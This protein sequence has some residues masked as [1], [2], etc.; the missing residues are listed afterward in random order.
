MSQSV[1][2]MFATLPLL[3]Q[4]AV[5]AILIT[6]L[7][8]TLGFIVGVPITFLRIYG[9]KLGRGFAYAYEWVLKGLPVLVTLFIL[10][11]GFPKLGIQIG[12]FAAIVIGLGLR[13]S[14]YQAQ[15]YRGAVLSISTE[16]TEAGLSLGLS[17]FCTFFTIIL[18][19]AF[20]LSLPG[21]TNEFTIV[22]KD[23]PLAY[24]VG[25][26]EILKQGRDITTTRGHT[27]A[28][29]LACSILYFALFQLFY[30]LFQQLN[31]K[32]AIPGFI[33]SKQ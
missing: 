9:N 2:F 15:I 26:V 23:S 3:L 28:V 18:P 8:I 13:S 31:K 21:F 16:Q 7:S 4:G 27:F 11:L 19:Q 1:F 6:V 14:A 24:A 30:F 25:I 17:R 20:R 33:F 12:S 5:V 22:L 29:Y 10:Y 32:F